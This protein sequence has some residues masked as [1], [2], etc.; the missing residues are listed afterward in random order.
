MPDFFAQLS[1]YL[2]NVMDFL[3]YAAEAVVTLTGLFKCL[4]PLWNNRR[5]LQ[6]AV[7][8]LQ[9]SAGT[10]RETPIWQETRFMGRRLKGSWQRFL[11]NAEQLDRRGLPCSVEEYINDETVINGPGNAQLAELIP[12]L[13]TSL[14]ILGTFIGLTRGIS[15]LDLSDSQGL[16]EGIPKLVEG[17]RYAFDTSVVG[18][19]CSLAFNMLNRVAVGSCY[20]AIDDFTESFTTLAMQ[21]PLD[22]DVQIICQNQDRNALISAAADTLSTQMAGSIELAVTR[23]LHPVAQSMDNF[24]VGAT[25][26]QVEGVGRIVN[27]FVEDM[28]ASLNHQFLELGET[29]TQINQHQQMTFA[30]VEESLQSAQTIVADVGR[31]HQVS[32]EIMEHFER[33]VKELGDARH[34]DEQFEQKTGD[35]LEKMHAACQDQEQYMGRLRE[36]QSELENG[37]ARFTQAGKDQLNS[38]RSGNEQLTRQLGEA[39]ESVAKNAQQLS[40]SYTSFVQHVVEGLSRSLGMFDQNMHSLIETFG[41]KVDKMNKDGTSGETAKQLGQMQKAMAAM[42]EAIERA[43]TSLERVAKGA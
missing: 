36:W 30:R 28:N 29:M 14:G 40:G 21:R 7:R 4:I 6:R 27:A 9:N 3:V 13:L 32:G 16:I 22:N 25:R 17:M 34:R 37:L 38:M 31:L 5:S 19:A 10:K 33:Y 12:T 11:Q 35:L 15:A 20:R 24:L 8:R 41:E 18:T 1:A 42:T 39:S 43:T 26:A 2:P 23:A